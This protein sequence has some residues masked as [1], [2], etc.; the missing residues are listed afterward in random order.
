[1]HKGYYNA[2]FVHDYRVNKI[3]FKMLIMYCLYQY[4]YV[5]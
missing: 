5:C 2:I 4:I 3:D 1:M